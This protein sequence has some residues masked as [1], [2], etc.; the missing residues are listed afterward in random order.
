MMIGLYIYVWTCGE[1]MCMYVC[2][3]TVIHVNLQGTRAGCCL[4]YPGVYDNIL[5]DANRI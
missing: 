5:V 3:G 2:D 1:C 4:Q